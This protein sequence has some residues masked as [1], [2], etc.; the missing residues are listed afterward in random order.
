M[1]SKFHA[2]ST[3]LQARLAST[4]TILPH[5]LD[6]RLLEKPPRADP[7]LKTTSIHSVRHILAC[8]SEAEVAGDTNL[9]RSL[10]A[11]LTDRS[12]IPA[13]V[14]IFDEDLRPGYYGTF[15]RSSRIVGARSPFARDEVALDYACDSGV[16]WDGEEEGAG[17]DVA[18]GEE[19]EQDGDEE[20]DSDLDSWL[21]DDDEVEEEVDNR[22]SPFPEL[23][24]SGLS[25]LPPPAKKRKVVEEETQPK[26]KKVVVPLVPFTKGPCLESKIGQCAYEPFAPYRIQLFNGI[27]HIP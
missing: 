24:F 23:A 15:T 22:S 3:V 27:P 17:E 11:L 6:P 25:A 19:E 7:S 20:R 10:T 16:E 14:F 4:L 21:V 2:N 9:V 1:V 13:R 5:S 12:R 26:K 18:D 8:L